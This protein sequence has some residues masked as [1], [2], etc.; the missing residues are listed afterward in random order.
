[1]SL[2]TKNTM[3][4]LAS[5]L[6]ATPAFAGYEYPLQTAEIRNAFFLGERGD[7]QTADF[8]SA[9]AHRL[10][11]AQ[12]GD[13]IISEIEV[14]T[15]YAQIVERG[16]HQA[17]GDSEVQT[18]TDLLAHPLR[19]EVKVTIIFNS[20]FDSTND[21]KG[22]SQGSGEDFSIQVEQERK[23]V[24]LKIKE[25]PIYSKHGPGGVV[26][27]LEF[28]PRKITSAPMHITVHTPDGRSISADFDMSKLK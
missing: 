22:S 5:F 4:I 8:L 6:F 12:T 17:S 28:D 21:S 24:P 27:T 13:L 10:R 2:S 11:K 1:M 16:A 23:L 20:H 7:Y 15:P 9:Y 26:H 19:F 25:V 14:L 18:E 3:V